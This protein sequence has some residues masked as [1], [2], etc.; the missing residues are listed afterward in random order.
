MADDTWTIAEDFAHWHCQGDIARGLREI[1]D[2]LG[3]VEHWLDT[4][5][6]RMRDFWLSSTVL[7]T[8]TAAFA[9]LGYG[10][11]FGLLPLWGI[12]LCSFV[13]SGALLGLADLLQ[14]LPSERIKARFKTQKVAPLREYLDKCI[15]SRRPIFDEHGTKIEHAILASPWA[16]L[17]LSK[18][19]IFRRLP[20][21]ISRDGLQRFARELRVAKPQAR[22]V[23]E[24]FAKPSNLGHQEIAPVNTEILTQVTAIA[25]L[26]KH[27]IIGLEAADAIWSDHAFEISAIR[28]PA[29]EG[30]HWFSRVP[31]ASVCQRIEL[32]CDFWRGMAARQV[33][34]MLTGAFAKFEEHPDALKPELKLAGIAQLQAEGLPMG[35]VGGDSE[36][37]IDKM[38]GE[39]KKHPYRRVREIL[40]DP[41]SDFSRKALAQH[42]LNL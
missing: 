24:I 8:A 14:Q 32:V 27:D 40:I 28:K 26:P 20:V 18:S 23:T 17:L 37:W 9:G 41:E 13:A 6:L 19:I 15:E 4:K 30:K 2:M 1:D 10:S 39:P 22:A 36:D 31:A 42:T 25:P 38:L 34:A 33:K 7:G 12:S 35:L 16:I 29:Q 3:D 21:Q 5:I 11:I